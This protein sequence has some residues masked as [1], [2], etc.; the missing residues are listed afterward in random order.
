VYVGDDTIMSMMVNECK[1]D[2]EFLF[3]QKGTITFYLIRNE[4]IKSVSGKIEGDD[5]LSIT[6][7]M[8][9]NS[10]VEIYIYNTDT[11]IK[12][13]IQ[14]GYLKTEVIGFMEDMSELD[15]H[16]ANVM[17]EDIFGMHLN[18]RNATVGVEDEGGNRF[19]LH[20]TNEADT[21]LDISLADDGCNEIFVEPKE[22]DDG[23]DSYI[24]RPH[25]Q[26]F[27]QIKIVVT[28]YGEM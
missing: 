11:N 21:T 14:D 10:F 5:N 16:I 26:P 25:E 20:I 27:I 9:D 13:E 19:N 1:F 18:I 24:I 12:A 23:V 28:R 4:D 15:N 8:K 2:N 6:V 7:E 22:Y 3:M 17:A